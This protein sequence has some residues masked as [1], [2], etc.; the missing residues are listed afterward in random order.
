MTSPSKRT[1]VKKQL[2]DQIYTFL[3]Q[4]ETTSDKDDKA[5]TLKQIFDVID[6]STQTKDRPNLSIKG[7]DF[8]TSKPG[9]NVVQLQG[10][11][12]KVSDHYLTLTG[13][14]L[15]A[16]RASKGSA[17]S[18]TASPTANLQSQFGSMSLNDP[19][20]VQESLHVD[21]NEFLHYL[22]QL[23]ADELQYDIEGGRVP[24]SAVKEA[25]TLLKQKQKLEKE[26][27]LKLQA[28]ARAA[29]L[30]TTLGTLTHSDPSPAT[31][32]SWRNGYDRLESLDTYKAFGDNRSNPLYSAKFGNAPS[33]YQ[34]KGESSAIVSEGEV[35]LQKGVKKPAK[36][37]GKVSKVPLELQKQAEPVG[38]E[39]APKVAEAVDIEDS[40]AVSKSGLDTLRSMMFG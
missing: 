1:P 7:Y 12:K 17:T 20:P 37:S 39:N 27:L 19:S 4:Y 36:P 24:P 15:I 40:P 25:K 33:E 6:G 22:A 31:Q 3:K 23:S 29:Q 32:S 35:K 30:S 28:Q 14:P 21:S 9:P 16:K 34:S 11:R 13:A 8:R 38:I 5:A 2:N 26:E 10:F 18:P